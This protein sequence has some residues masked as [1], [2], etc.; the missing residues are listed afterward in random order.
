MNVFDGK[1]TPCSDTPFHAGN[2][3]S[4]AGLSVSMVCILLR[5]SAFSILHLL[6]LSEYIMHQFSDS[7]SMLLL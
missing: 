1:S 7:Y 4:K 5:S 6:F 2:N 3:R